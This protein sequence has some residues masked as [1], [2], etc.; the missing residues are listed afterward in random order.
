MKLNESNITREKIQNILLHLLKQEYKELWGITEEKHISHIVKIHS[1]IGQDLTGNI[2]RLSSEI[3]DISNKRILDFGCGWGNFLLYCLINRYNA[4]G[5]DISRT[6]FRFFSSVIDMLELPRELKSRY[7]IYDGKTLPFKEEIFD[8]V[9]ANQVLEHVENIENSIREINRVLKRSGFLYV[10]SPDYSRS[11][12]E[13][14]YKLVWFPGLK[15]KFAKTY[16]RFFRKPTKGLNHI[17]FISKGKLINLLNEN[18]FEILADMER[19]IILDG[20]KEKI[21]EKVKF[22]PESAIQVLNKAYEVFRQVRMI[23][24]Q[25]NQIDIIA[26]KI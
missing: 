12:F 18:G 26:R 13:P 17:N 25:E 19:K 7:I 14:H 6:R 15:G 16:I 22:L 20:R 11:F 3:G 2:N 1:E 5:V 10:R 4:L 23:G 21:R 24:K 9:L 8:I